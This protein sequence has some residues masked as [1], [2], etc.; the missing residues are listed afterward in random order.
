MEQNET[1]AAP[2]QLPPPPA[3]PRPQLP[4][5]SPIL[6]GFLSFFPGLGNVYNGLYRRAVSIFV[7]WVVILA[8]AINA[9]EEFLGLVVAFVWF[10]NIFD[11][12]RQATLLNLGLTSDPDLLREQASDLGSWGLVPGVVLLLLGFY[13]LL[14]EYLDLDLSW[15]VDQ[16]PIAVMALGGWMIYQTLKQR[17]EA[18]TS[19]E[20]ESTSEM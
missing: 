2:Q 8:I 14:R 20:T 6:A 19:A 12:Y 7:V 11:A 10:F 16:W 13:G 18:E 3:A 1:H 5:K 15:L 4:Q 9:D 17:K